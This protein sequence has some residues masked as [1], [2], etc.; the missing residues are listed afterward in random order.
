[1]QNWIEN[2]CHCGRCIFSPETPRQKPVAHD[3]IGFAG[4]LAHWQYLAPDCTTVLLAGVPEE[5]ADYA[6]LLHCPICGDALD[7][8]GIA[9]QTVVIPDHPGTLTI[10]EL[11]VS[12]NDKFTNAEFYAL[13]DDGCTGELAGF[14]E[15]DIP[16]GLRP[17]ISAPCCYL[18]IPEEP[19]D[20]D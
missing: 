4:R 15:E 1:M 2:V 20:A 18:L 9:R 6:K 12:Q 10:R 13:L 3:A 16:R 7:G 11:G 14:G 17:P 5:R 8:D 19:T